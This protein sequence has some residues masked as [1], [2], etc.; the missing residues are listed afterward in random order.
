MV[1]LS[2][3]GGLVYSFRPTEKTSLVSKSFSPKRSFGSWANVKRRL[4][5]QFAR[6]QRFIITARTYAGMSRPRFPHLA[7]LSYGRP[8]HS[9][10]AGAADRVARYLAPSGVEAA[11]AA[12][13]YKQVT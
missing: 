1:R 13:G 10:R 6:R 8:C 5:R 4:A 11:V 7:V 12:P 9:F 2:C 3:T